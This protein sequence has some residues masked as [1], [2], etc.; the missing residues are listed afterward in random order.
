[1]YKF[2]KNIFKVL[3]SNII[4][5]LSGVLVGF[6]VPKM[7]GLVGY[8][9]YKTYTLYLTYIALLSLGLGDGL[10]LRFSGIDKEEL[11]INQIKYYLHKYYIQL[12]LIF[13]PV[14]VISI[15]A[16]P[17]EQKFICVALSV[18]ILSSQI[19]AVHQNLSVITSRFNEY[20]TRV[21]VKASLT[22]IF[23]II[24]YL[25]YK[26]QGRE[27]TYQVYIIGVMI[28]DFLLAFWYLYT[29]K[30]FNFGKVD[31]N[32]VTGESYLHLLQLGFPLL[33]S[34]MA[35]SIFLNFDRQFVSILFE[36]E[37]YAI[38]A[39]AYNM[40][41][42]I[43]TMT[44]AVSLVLFPALRKIKN[45]DVK[46]G[47]NKYIKYF[48]MIVALCLI[49]FFPLCWIVNIFLP[50]YRSSLEVF[51]IVLPGLIFSSSVSVILNNFY[52]Y[53]NKVQRYFIGTA[54]AIV[55]SIILNFAAYYI[56]GTYLSISWV[57]MIALI[58]WYVISYLY[59]IKKYKVPF[60]VN[61]LYIISISV[62]FYIITKMIRNWIEAG[63][64]YLIVYIIITMLFNHNII[65]EM[66]NKVG[67]KE[68]RKSVV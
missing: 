2:M 61:F 44:S 37:D 50:K 68:D 51:R 59:F 47:L 57:S 12:I 63:I 5:L 35:G 3:F 40:L 9:N 30:E 53:E 14:F 22:S 28:I 34:N 10:Y 31:R 6:L 21:I 38:Y 26:M 23:V 7:M 55:F 54:S 64:V 25:I 60:A 45:L 46:I 58:Y 43:T 52:K 49:V 16:V 18:T 41:T 19:T 4:S 66:K 67:Y 42:L 8:A 29:Y 24:L 48:N 65:I 1:M 36:K 17:S 13:I 33:V 62:A 15:I 56:W 32:Y 11:D 20:S 39:F 27:I